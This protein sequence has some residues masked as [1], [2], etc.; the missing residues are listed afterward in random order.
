MRR[1]LL[2]L[3]VLA[4]AS[5]ASAQDV[6]SGG[7]GGWSFSAAA[8]AYFVPDSKDFLLP[9]A[10]ADH[11]MLHLE[12]RYQYEDLDTGSVWAGANFSGGKDLEW[13]VTPILGLVFGSLDGIAPGYK[14]S[15]RWKSLE[16][17]SEGE[18][19]FDFSGSE[20]NFFY[21]WSELTVSPA[22][23]VRLGIVTQRTRLYRSDREINRGLLAGFTYGRVTLTGYVLNPD[24][25]PTWIASLGVEF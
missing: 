1:S 22:E 11:G 24:D 9:V 7:G 21:N 23:W 15:L 4:L 18:Y 16:L 14:G 17:Y 5:R 3:L 8:Y 6:A 25:E 12:A 2:A 10:T 13:E 20:G 19:V